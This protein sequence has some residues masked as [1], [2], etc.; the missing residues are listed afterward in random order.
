MTLRDIINDGHLDSEERVRLTFETY[1]NERKIQA[2]LCCEVK[3]IPDI[4]L[5]H[6]DGFNFSISNSKYC[7]EIVFNG[8]TIFYREVISN[9]FD[10]WL[11]VKGGLKRWL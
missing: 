10:I 4:M 8:L 5:D 2:W 3:D 6:K 7:L 1:I 11:E 9:M